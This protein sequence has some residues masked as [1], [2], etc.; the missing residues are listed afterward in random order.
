MAVAPTGAIYKAMTI[1]G[2]SSRTYGVYITGQ[3]VYNAPQREV[4]M[5]SVPGRNGQLALDKGRF[6]NIEVTYPAGI[7]ADTEA[8]FAEAVSNFRNFLCSRDGY[9][10]IEDEYNPNEYR[11]GVYKSGLE[12]TPAMLKAGEFEIIFDCKPQRWLTEG[13]TAVTIG[14]WG[15]TETAT[16]DIVTVENEDGV[17]GVKSLS[18]DLQPIQDLHGYDKPWS[19]GNGKNLF[20]D[21]YFIQNQTDASG[22]PMPDPYSLSS[23]VFTISTNVQN[24][25]RRFL[26]KKQM[27]VGTYTFSFTPTL[28]GTNKEIGYSVRDMD[29]LTNIVATTLATITDG[30]RMS[31]TFTVST[32]ANIAISLQPKENASGTLTFKNVQLESGSTMTAYEPYSNICPIS[33]RAEV[34]TQRT[35]K[36]LIP[37]PFRDGNRTQ[38]GIAWTMNSDG[39]LNA[40]GTA[41]TTTYY[42]MYGMNTTSLDTLV[43]LTSLGLQ[44]GDTVTLS[45]NYLHFVTVQCNKDD[46][47]LVNTELSI[48]GGG[49]V[50]KTLPTTAK[51]VYI[52]LRVLNG[53]TVNQDNIFVQLEKGT[54]ATSYELYQCDTYTTD[55]G[56]T[57]Y[58][59]EVEQV[60]GS[61]TDK[62]A[63][64]DMGDLT[65]TYRPL[66][67]GRHGFSV[68]VPDLALAEGGSQYLPAISSAYVSKRYNDPWANGDMSYYLSTGRA[69]IFINNDYT[70]ATQFKTAMSGVQLCYELAEPQTYQLTPQQVSLI[71]GENNVWSE[72]GEVTLEYGQ[73]P[74]LLINPTLFEASPLLEVEGYGNIQIGDSNI[75]LS[76]L[77]IGNITVLPNEFEQKTFPQSTDM[78]TVSGQY[79][80]EQFNQG[81]TLTLSNTSIRLVD[82]AGAGNKWSSYSVASNAFFN[83][84]V[85]G[86]GTPTVTVTLTPKNNITHAVGT[87]ISE[88]IKTATLTNRAVTFS[89]GSATLFDATV[90]FLYGVTVNGTEETLTEKCYTDNRFSSNGVVTLFRGTMRGYSTVPVL[91]N[92]T[93]IDCELGDAYKI[94]DGKIIGANS[95]V[96]LGSD[97]PKL[98]TGATT[99]TFDNSVTD[100]KVYPRWWKV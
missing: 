28:S 30:T 15:E 45:S 64:V 3:A 51:Y 79:S 22:N 98:T 62:M 42:G 21:S 55:L 43:P 13:E 80:T 73:L 58:G 12:V 53:E 14:E 34:V 27:A 38:Y 71:T 9:V 40:H 44:G 69:V 78:I 6:E 52:G 83:A 94:E 65:Y 61:L 90:S 77:P 5:I 57:V 63:I 31:F 7:Y 17:L 96:D 70:D 72:D 47:T 24:T 85:A 4:E 100:L 74:N 18:V 2:E 81:D 54:T 25:G 95:R 8:E 92:P 23:G 67:G 46:G 33:G 60:G 20:N 39:T 29:S 87:A 82:Y 59:G 76:N 93:Y 36:N 84:S 41:S 1:D 91:G 37:F 11:M 48:D 35:G 66:S 99:I 26:N 56:R 89:G 32:S 50:T 88:T 97:V 10:R 68:S 16:G 19:A 75:S 49:S 86:V